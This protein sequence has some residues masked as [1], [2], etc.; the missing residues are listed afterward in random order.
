MPSAISCARVTHV[1]MEEAR[2]SPRM[3]MGTLLVNSVPASVLFDSGASHSFMSQLFA[4]LHGLAMEPLATSLAVNA[5]GS[6]SRA[7]MMSPDTTIA[8]VGL[9]FPAPLIILKSS[10]I[11][12]ILGMDW[13]GAHDA[14]IHCA[15]K[16]VQLTPP[17][18]KKILY[19]SRTAQHAEGHIYALNALN[20]S[21]LEGIENVRVV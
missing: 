7:T 15:T 1:N 9:L 19:S 10:N 11:D 12:V 5:V 16:T 21:P 17:S 20:T 2:E 6:Q 13:L 18:G 8:I 14:H 4:H 3:V